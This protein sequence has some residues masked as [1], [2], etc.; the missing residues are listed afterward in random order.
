MIPAPPRRDDGFAPRG[1]R[2][3]G[4]RDREQRGGGG[5]RDREQRGP[6]EAR[7]GDW[8]CSCGF[9]NFGAFLLRR[10]GLPRWSDSRRRTLQPAARSAVSAEQAA[11]RY[12][13]PFWPGTVVM[14]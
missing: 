10:L 9:S 13:A 5:F 14:N 1:G 2:G 3:G 11:E 6:P 8:A 7:P 4:F 12:V